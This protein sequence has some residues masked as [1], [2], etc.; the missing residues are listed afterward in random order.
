MRY[1]ITF[2]ELA[3]PDV[4]GE[5]H[6]NDYSWMLSGASSYFDLRG[7]FFLA[8]HLK[9]DA[10]L[11]TLFENVR[12]KNSDQ[13]QLELGVVLPDLFPN[14]EGRPE[15]VVSIAHEGTTRELA[16]SNV[17]A[18][19]RFT[20]DEHL[21][22]ALIPRRALP[23]VRAGEVDFIPKEASVELLRTFS[24]CRFDIQGTTAEEA[25]EEKC[26]TC[27]H[28]MIERLNRL[29][30]IMP[31]VDLAE[32]RVYSVAYSRANLPPF[33][34]ILK[35]D[36]EENLGHGWI[37]PHV[38][39]TMLNPP[40]LPSEQ[41]ALL[42]AYL[43]GTKNVDDVQAFL[44]AARTFLDGGVNEYVL[45]LSVIA[46]EVATQRFVE[47]RLLSSS[48]SKTKLVE[49]EKD[50]TYSLVLNI[51]LFAVTPDGRKPDKEL[52]GKMNRARSLRNDYMHEG[53]L[54]M[55][56]REL[57]DLFENTKRFVQYLRELDEEM[58]KKANHG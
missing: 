49:A 43:G 8:P 12:P 9:K 24:T 25:L 14:L 10:S 48:V 57:V 56:Q 26:D 18:R 58:S 21:L 32:G 35:G 47:K 34:F 52:V 40:N 7:Y 30:K 3:T 41:V 50:L 4:P 28:D 44:H 29:L 31:F 16:F 55:D 53:K 2:V 45:L 33:Y 37:S 51:V 27:M 19:L 42:T 17:M 11:G 13:F 22:H 23:K 36:S 39:R 54:P 46:A 5:P 6:L 1:P 20:R 15:Y 38:G